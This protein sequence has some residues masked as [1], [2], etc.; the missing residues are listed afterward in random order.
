[1]RFFSRLCASL[2]SSNRLRWVLHARIPSATPSNAPTPA[3]NTRAV[4]SI[5]RAFR[6]ALLIRSSQRKVRW[7]YGEL[8]RNRPTAWLYPSVNQNCGW[9]RLNSPSLARCLTH[10]FTFLCSIFQPTYTP[11]SERVGWAKS[12][13]LGPPRGHRA[14]AILPTR[15]D[16]GARGAH[17]TNSLTQRRPYRLAR[18][19]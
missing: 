19:A 4:M 14:C 2:C 6:A 7:Q 12:S 8:C 18:S 1:M 10:R 13:A 16:F 9:L 3:A 17:P 5:A 11:V 15:A